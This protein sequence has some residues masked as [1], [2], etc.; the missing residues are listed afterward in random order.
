MHG[1]SS[2]NW[3]PDCRGARGERSLVRPSAGSRA[4][5]G[6]A[7]VASHRVGSLLLRTLLR[8]PSL[9]L[10]LWMEGPWS[11]P[12]FLRLSLLAPQKRKQV[13]AFKSAGFCWREFLETNQWRYEGK[14]DL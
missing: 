4:H 8:V 13:K 5:S 11:L 14:G 2:D 3:N 10:V 9:S 12:V 1:G 7:Y 6:L